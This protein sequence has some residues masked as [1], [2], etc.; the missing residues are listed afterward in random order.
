M[1]RVMNF[2]ERRIGKMIGVFD[3]IYHGLAVR[4]CRM[5][6]GP[7]GYWFSFPQKEYSDGNVV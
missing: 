3:L 2:K 6:T 5:M 4:G 7:N 1:V